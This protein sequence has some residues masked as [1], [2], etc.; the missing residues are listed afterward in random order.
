PGAP[1]SHLMDAMA[2]AREPILD[3]LGVQFE[4]SASE[5][6]AAALLGASIHYPLRGAVTWK[7]IVGTN[8]AS[9]ALSNLS[10]AG[11]VGGTLV[12][13]G[14]DYGEGASVIQE[15]TIA[16]AL[17][18]SM[19]LIDPRYHLPT[20]VRLT[21]AAFEMSE[22]SNLP[23]L[24]SL[25]IRAAHMTGRFVCKDN[26]PP[27]YGLRG[28]RL[29]ARA[30]YGKIVL[31][32]SIYIQEKAKFED[33]LPRARAYIR[34][35]GLNE[36]L[37]ADDE[38]KFGII[39]QGGT[40]GVVQRALRL[41]GA[42][43]AFGRTGVPML[44]LNVI[45]PLVPEEISEFLRGKD[46]VL[47]V[48][49]GNPALIEQ[50]VRVLA[51]AAGIPCRVHGKDILPMA[52]EYVG[53]VVR[54]G[55]AR[56]LAEAGDAALAEQARRR[57][58]ALSDGRASA[59]SSLN[60][61]VPARPPGFCTGCP[62]RPIFTA[63]KLLQRERGR[64]HIS[65]D[66][67]CN[68]FSTLPPFNIGSTVLGYGLSLASGGAVG[69]A[70]GQP[71]IAVMGDGGFWH[72]GFITG[73]V[74]AQWNGHDGVLVILEN[75]YASA[76]GQQHL[77]STG[78]TP[79]GRSIRMSIESA[80]RGLGIDWIRRI[81][82]YDLR[83]TLRALR[84]ALDQRRAGLRVVISD[85]ECMLARQRRERPALA[86]RMKAGQPVV[87]A[88]FGVDAEICVG[89]HSCMNVNGCPSLTLK[90]ATDPFKDGPTAHIDASCVACGLC[91][92]VVRATALC[93]S[94]HEAHRIVNPTRWQ[95]LRADLSRR[96]LTAMGA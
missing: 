62:E 94:F 89:D 22:A 67:G 82:S 5:A 95:R 25:R 77:P 33:R 48:E 88:R 80:L 20:I 68:T 60:M 26:R 81:D 64:M 79:W 69:P 86:A 57:N 39:L 65:S 30:D 61:P 74:N 40:Y 75:G 51:Q 96:L 18:S 6:G 63:L 1:V 36:R 31:P 29:S 53:D 7:S 49:E 38:K 10:S 35:H 32:P 12:I 87:H 41:L 23:A 3:P 28:Q 47:I 15:R 11:V 56:Y 54:D 34:R 2:E 72:N 44:V 21:E 93:P 84:A 58:G 37:G 52:G 50:Q 27:P 92:E 19:L 70:L 9:D 59:Q 90:P 45:H 46:S 76:T 8:V 73:A 85:Q 13:I 4:A 42:A 14:E 17:K 24:M 83:A 66:V 78:T 55:V 43:D 91:G 16:T 71:A